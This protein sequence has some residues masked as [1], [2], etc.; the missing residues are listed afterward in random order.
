MDE[1]VDKVKQVLTNWNPL[2]NKASQIKDLDDYET[3]AYDILFYIN[4]KSSTDHINK[5]MV[6]VLSQAFGV[7]L[8]LETTRKYAEEIRGIIKYDS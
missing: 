4:K 8:D 1:H 7:Y 2:G 3:E 6:D 5:I